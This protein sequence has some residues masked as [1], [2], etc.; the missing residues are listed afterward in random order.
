MPLTPLASGSAPAAMAALHEASQSPLK[1]DQPAAAAGAAPPPPLPAPPASEAAAPE[2]AVPRGSSRAPQKEMS[3]AERRALQEA[4]RAAKAAAKAEREGG[5]AGG[6]K[7]SKT[8]SSGSLSRQPT[9]SNLAPTA[10]SPG[11]AKAQSRQRGSAKG[12]ASETSAPGPPSKATALFMHLPQFKAITVEQVAQRGDSA[13]V[14]VECMRLGLQMADGQVRG[15]NARCSAMMDMFAEVIRGFKVPPGKTFA[16]ECGALLNSMVSFLVGC[17]PLSP[18]MGNAVKAVK[19]ELGR[20]TADVTLTD[21]QAKEQ[22]LAHIATFVHEKIQFARE[23]LAR[24]AAAKIQEGDV[25]LTYAHSS[26]V[27]AVLY[28]AKA[29]GTRFSV[30][31]VDARPLLE[32]RV[33]LRR[34]LAVGIPCEYLLLN[35]LEIGLSQ[36]TK[37]ILGAAAVMSNGAVLSRL[38]TAAVAMSAA[39]AHVPVMVCAETYKFHERVQ[40]DCITYNELAD[41][42]GLLRD[43]GHGGASMREVWAVNDHL[44]MLNLVYDTT[45]SEFVTVVMTEVG[46]LPPTSVP[47][48]LREYR[49]EMSLAAA[50]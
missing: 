39:A 27:E 3:K 1:Q 12:A 41:P 21:F 20:L 11:D 30:V 13:S 4:Q 43:T 6:P 22:L 15:A 26:T 31:V 2:T 10:A 50:V 8:M 24:S 49:T 42:E 36:A 25:V 17:R 38:G 19:A 48:V 5:A 45:P 14:P 35:G 37:V 9:S 33:L 28:A 40:L 29:E 44:S 23:A 32:G 7:I 18:A 47:V 34:L 16:R 46:A